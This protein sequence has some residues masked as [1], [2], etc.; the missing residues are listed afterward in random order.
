MEKDLVALLKQEYDSDSISDECKNLVLEY[1]KDTQSLLEEDI[2]N[3]RLLV[4][5]ARHILNSDP[6]SLDGS[7]EKLYQF[8]IDGIQKTKKLIEG[9]A[10]D[11]LL[12]IRA[13]L[14]PSKGNVAKALFKK[15]RDI[16]WAKQWYEDY[17]MSADMTIDTEPLHSAHASYFAGNAARILYEKTKKRK[18]NK[19]A[20]R[21]YNKFLSY[22]ESNPNPRMN[23]LINN[24]KSKIDY[25]EN[26]YK[27]PK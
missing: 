10:Q 27:N 5:K 24:A 22:Y 23:K 14:Y 7:L 8:H 3:I 18:W 20:I 25:L 6:D 13:H 15:T 16:S 2:L 19:I 17:K 4:K 11:D 21:C 26:S 1:I 9:Y 12:S